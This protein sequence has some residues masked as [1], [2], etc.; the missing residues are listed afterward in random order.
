MTGT[1]AFVLNNKRQQLHF[2]YN[3]YNR[4]WYLNGTRQKRMNAVHAV[5]GNI[6]DTSKSTGKLTE[7]I[8]KSP[9]NN[10]SNN[11]QVSTAPMNPRSVLNNDKLD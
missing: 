3:N 11:I 4:L 6:S 1:S 5:A 9:F 7:V 8:N 2:T 10:Y